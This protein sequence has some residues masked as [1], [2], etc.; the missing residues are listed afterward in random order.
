VRAQGLDQGLIKNLQRDERTV[1]QYRDWF[2][3]E[4]EYDQ[5]KEGTTKADVDFHKEFATY[6][7]HAQTI[8]RCRRSIARIENTY[9]EALKDKG[10]QYWKYLREAKMTKQ[11][12]AVRRSAH[13]LVLHLDTIIKKPGKFQPHKVYDR[14]RSLTIVLQNWRRKLQA[15]KKA[16]ESARRELSGG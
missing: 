4:V 5:R 10:N 3:V 1:R 8:I 12:K 11:C 13:E 9:T 14:L 7:H 15:Q 16:G 6:D 2:D